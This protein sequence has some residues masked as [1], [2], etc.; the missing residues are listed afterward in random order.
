MNYLALVLVFVIIIILYMIYTYVTNTSLTSGLQKLNE[1]LTFQPNKLDKP[2]SAT[3]SYQCWLF[4]SGNSTSG[5]TLFKRS[6]GNNIEN[7]AAIL[8]NTTLAIKAGTG[9]GSPSTIMSV[10]DQFP[11]QKWVYLVINVFSNGTLEAY[12]NGRL[13][14]TVNTKASDIK[15]SAIAPLT[16]G[17]SS[18]TGG[19]V[20]KFTRL[21][22]TLDAQTIQTNYYAGNGISNIFSTIIPYGMNMTIS[23]GEEVQKS[24]K[25][26]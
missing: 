14:K 24:I 6:N 12:M 23:K 10:T 3:Y 7:F 15:P 4:L 22:S 8:N 25:I 20:T 17:D 19:Y 2:G 21:P 5:R 13:V 9:S 1:P 16:I 11:M 26:F 18:L